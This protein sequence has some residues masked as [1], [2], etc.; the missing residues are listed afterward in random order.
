MRMLT[1]TE[2][3]RLASIRVLRGFFSGI[4]QLLLAADRF[5][6]EEAATESGLAD[7]NGPHD[8]LG[9][10]ESRGAQ[11]S[12]ATAAVADRDEATVRPE[13]TSEQARPER[14]AASSGKRRPSARPGQSAA[15]DRAGKRGQSGPPRRKQGAPRPVAEQSASRPL[16]PTGNVRLLTSDD[17]GEPTATPPIPGY[18]DF[19][20]ASLRARLRGLSAGQLRKLVDYERSHA[21]RDDVVTM[22][23]RR[24]AK[25]EAGD[26]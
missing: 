24:I 3:V 5:R 23:E 25:L 1:V 12:G 22:F 6:A 2:Q 10:W 14:P 19:S 13:P 21:N 9:G 17:P 20:L 4:G 8:P 16:D 26:G 15:S 18:D 7:T 11:A